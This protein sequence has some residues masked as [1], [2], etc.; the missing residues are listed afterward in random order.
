MAGLLL[1]KSLRNISDEVLVDERWE[2]NSFYQYFCGMEYYKRCKPSASSDLVHFRKRIG[3]LG[4]KIILE[5]SI[6]IHGRAKGSSTKKEEVV[7]SV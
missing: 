3:E 1:L 2:E 7:Y 6:K 4:V 5:A